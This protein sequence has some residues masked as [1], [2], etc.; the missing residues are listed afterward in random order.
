MSNEITEKVLDLIASTARIS[1]DKVSINNTFDELGMDSLDATNLVFAIEEEFNIS[2]PDE[3]ARIK[4]VRQLV[5]NLGA[6]LAQR[7]NDV[8]QPT[9]AK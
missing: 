5:E 4:D 6:V 7:Q 9:F 3:A 8:D 2:V 1:R